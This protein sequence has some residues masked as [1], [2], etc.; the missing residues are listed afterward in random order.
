[1]SPY[2]SDG[3]MYAGFNMAADSPIKSDPVAFSFL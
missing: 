2:I 3:W 1:M